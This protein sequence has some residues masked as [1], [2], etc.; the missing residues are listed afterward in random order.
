MTE[1]RLHHFYPESSL[2]YFSDADG[3]TWVLPK[4]PSHKPFKSKAKNV[5]RQRDF[6]A[7]DSPE[8]P[9]R[10]LLENEFSKIEGKADW[11][12]KKII[13]DQKPLKRCLTNEELNDL[14]LFIGLFATRTP[15]IRNWLNDVFNRFC[16]KMSSSILATKEKFLE[17]ARKAGLTDIKEEDYDRFREFHEA[18]Q[19]RIIPPKNFLLSETLKQAETITD[20]LLRRNWILGKSSKHKFITCDHPVSLS[21]IEPVY[22]RRPPGFGLK[23]TQV[24]LPLTPDLCLIGIF[25]TIPEDILQLD[26]EDVPIINSKTLHQASEYL[27]SSEEGLS[28]MMPGNRVGQLIDYLKSR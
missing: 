27:Y 12:I 5:A 1:P 7:I 3:F 4:D 15:A 28:W 2:K 19:H 16:Q 23:N 21:W 11:V 6:Y 20:C 10:H 14:L 17:T 25:E 9:D 13:A 18:G 8:G 22:P 24:I 26:E